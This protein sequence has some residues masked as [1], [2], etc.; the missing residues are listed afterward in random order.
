M[1][2]YACLATFSAINQ[3]ILWVVAAFSCKGI[4]SKLVGTLEGTSADFIEKIDNT[5]TF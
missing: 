2:T 1:P 3:H 5:A 4:N